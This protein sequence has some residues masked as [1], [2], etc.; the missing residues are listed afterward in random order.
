MM[1]FL[2]PKLALQ[3]LHGVTGKRTVA[4]CAFPED[5][6]ER[7]IYCLKLHYFLGS[8]RVVALSD[9]MMIFVNKIT[10]YRLALSTYRR[11][12]Q[13]KDSFVTRISKRK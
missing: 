1:D 8:V 5:N 9:F 13:I 2:V 6:S 3:E 7:L 4:A 10:E 12:F 11:K